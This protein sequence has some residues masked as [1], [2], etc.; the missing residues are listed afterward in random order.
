MICKDH[1]SYMRDFLFFVYILFP[2]CLRNYITI[3]ILRRILE[4]YFGYEIQFI[5]NITDIDDKVSPLFMDYL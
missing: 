4:D 3:D 1:V 2:K 5:M